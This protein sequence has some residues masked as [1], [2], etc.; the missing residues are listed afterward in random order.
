MKIY[1]DNKEVSSNQG[2]NEQIWEEIFSKKEWGKYPSES[3]IRFIA[4]NFYNVQDR[5]KINILELG[6][7]TGANLW[8]CA[9]EGFKVSG[10]EWSKTGLER[11]RARL[12]DENLST[13][14]EQ[15]EIGDYLEK[16]DLFKNESFD[17]WMDSY[18]LAYN[19]FEKTKQIIKKAMKKL[20]I[21]GKFFSITPS[22]YNE[23]FEKDANLGYHLVKPV[24]GTDAFTGVI[25]Y[26]DEEDLKRLYEGEGYKITSIKIHIQKDL[27]KQLNE[28]YI[29]EGERY[30]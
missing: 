25:R 14:I 10:I 29:I 12:K 27:E 8:F 11:F 2:S 18:S 30:E 1:A 20:K 26:C 7:G 24:S 23:G 6:L 21:G 13:Q 16:L 19:D 5:S 3:V 22:L 4:R 15:I 28:L 9:R 17:A